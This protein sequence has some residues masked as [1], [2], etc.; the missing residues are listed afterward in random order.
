MTLA[1]HLGLV[2]A[3]END[4]RAWAFA[5]HMEDLKEVLGALLLGLAWPSSTVVLIWGA[6]Q[7]KEDLLLPHI[8]SLSLSLSICFFSRE[9]KW[10]G[11]WKSEM[12]SRNSPFGVQS[13]ENSSPRS[14]E[15][16]DEMRHLI[17]DIVTLLMYLDIEDIISVI[18]FS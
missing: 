18:K 5:I 3:T 8:P 11:R 12:A 1:S 17:P 9:G 16:M 6:K 7:Q 4:S 13:L 10:C 14:G 2:R 15:P